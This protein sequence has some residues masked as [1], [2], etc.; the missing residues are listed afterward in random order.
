MVFD[1]KNRIL[2]LIFLLLV[3]VLTTC[4]S[5]IGGLN[6]KKD[7]PLHGD[8]DG[9]ANSHQTYK[10]TIGMEFVF[11]EPG[12]FYMGSTALAI[13]GEQPVHKVT[14]SQGFYMGKY[15][16]TQGQWVEIMGNN[17][18]NSNRGIGE[19]YPVSQISWNEV[20]TF[21]TKL[22][23]KE[24]GT[25][26]RLPTEAEWEYC[27]HAGS[28]ANNEGPYF[29][30]DETQLRNYAWYSTNSG[31]TSH[32]VG[33]KKPNAYGLYDMH[34]NVFEWVQDWFGSYSTNAEIN[35]QGPS[36]G[37]NRVIRSGS[38]RRDAIDVRSALRL[39]DPPD[40]YGEDSGFRLLRLQ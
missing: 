18:S 7:N 8:V 2:G 31:N 33:Q 9:S 28:A 30:N 20:Q 21:I 26:Y 40:G 27:A 17:P 12:S 36:S 37:L 38:W 35:P 11:I 22:N 16:V 4:E 24:G 34:G 6:Y 5:P 29:G 25:K 15:E 1:Y 23:E 14:I 3:M 39:G 32:E 19:N 10:N 13:D